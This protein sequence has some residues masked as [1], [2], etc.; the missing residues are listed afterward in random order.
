MK[1]IKA[2]SVIVVGV[3]IMG[4]AASCGQG[5]LQEQIDILKNQLSFVIQLSL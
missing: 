1:I 4:G 3:L 2:L 5:D